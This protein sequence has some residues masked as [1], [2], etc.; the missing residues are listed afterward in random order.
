[1]LD[2]YSESRRKRATWKVMFEIGEMLKLGFH[3]RERPE[4]L[5]PASLAALGRDPLGLFRVLKATQ[6]VERE[7]ELVRGLA[8]TRDQVALV[9]DLVLKQL[10]TGTAPQA[11]FKKSSRPPTTRCLTLKLPDGRMSASVEPSLWRHTRPPGRQQRS[12][13]APVGGDLQR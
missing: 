1:M 8:A 6:E 3:V 2:A 11:K 4:V 9:G 7:A 5:Q 12:T 13:V 10:V